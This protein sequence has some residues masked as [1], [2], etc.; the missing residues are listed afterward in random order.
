[1]KTAGEATLMAELSIH[2][3]EAVMAEL[4][5]L[6]DLSKEHCMAASQDEV[7]QRVLEVRYQCAKCNKTP[8]SAT[9]SAAAAS[10]STATSAAETDA[11]AKV[12]A[13]VEVETGW[14][15]RWEQKRSTFRRP[16]QRRHRRTLRV[17]QRRRH[18]W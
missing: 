18:E 3:E 12:E 4:S 6:V 5:R 1:M 7:V 15:Q 14:R 16:A 17:W 11:E 8:A 2:S 13:G 9:R 10:R